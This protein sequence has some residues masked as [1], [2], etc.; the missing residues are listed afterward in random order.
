MLALSTRELSQSSGCLRWPRQTGSQ[1]LWCTPTYKAVSKTYSSPISLPLLLLLHEKIWVLSWLCLERT[2]TL[3]NF[4]KTYLLKIKKAAAVG[5]QSFHRYKNI[6]WHRE[7]PQTKGF[8]Q[9]T[10]GNTVIQLLISYSAGCWF[11]QKRMLIY[12]TFSILL[13]AAQTNKNSAFKN[14]RPYPHASSLSFT[15]HTSFVQYL[16]DSHLNVRIIK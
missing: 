15:W 12:F 3:G 4:L 2:Q 1:S 8:P 6:Q 10:A 13:T 9:P 14:T 7:F 5:V 11:N 16:L